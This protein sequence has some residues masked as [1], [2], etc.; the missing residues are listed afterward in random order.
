MFQKL[1]P[2]VNFTNVIR[3]RFFVR[4]FQQSQNVTRKTTL[5]QNIR[6]YNVDEI[7]TR[8]AVIFMNHAT[9]KTPS[10][11]NCI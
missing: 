10:G 8:S 11:D 5:V 7:D 1:T 3:A 9:L 4:I 2:V 6:T